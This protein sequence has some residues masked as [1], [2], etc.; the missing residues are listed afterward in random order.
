M[1]TPNT[2]ALRR[3]E[4]FEFALDFLS[5]PEEPVIRAYVEALEARVAALE[6]QPEP[7]GPT[8]KEISDWII[9][10]KKNSAKWAA[11]VDHHDALSIACAAI[12]DF[13]RW[14]HPSTKPEAA[15]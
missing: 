13:A 8:L 12:H 14:G 4:C 6:A 3:P 1:T 7:V 9:S 10:E 11:A 15:Q 2:V 5:E